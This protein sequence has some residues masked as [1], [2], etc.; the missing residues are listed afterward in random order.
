MQR[1]NRVDDPHGER[2]EP[3]EG[4]GRADHVRERFTAHQLTQQQPSS[5]SF[6][7]ESR[8]FKETW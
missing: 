7:V 5:W 3:I 1:R 6:E 4:H 2:Q 8:P